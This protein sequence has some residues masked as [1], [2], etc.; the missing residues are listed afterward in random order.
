MLTTH[1]IEELANLDA[2]DE[3]L[4]K[5]KASLGIG[6]GGTAMAEGAGPKV[7]VL[8]LFLTSPTLPPGKTISLDLTDNA[9]LEG[10]KANPINI[11]EGVEYR[12]VIVS[13][14]E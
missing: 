11:K 5:W 14:S 7:T 13:S 8:T 4:N 6:P 9:L 1:G 3:S 2:A 12:C 10:L